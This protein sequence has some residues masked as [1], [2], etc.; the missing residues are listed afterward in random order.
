VKELSRRTAV[1]CV[2]L[3]T[4]QVAMLAVAADDVTVSTN[5]TVI[6][7][8]D[9]YPSPT[10]SGGTGGS[11]GSGGGGSGDSSGGGLTSPPVDAGGGEA[12]VDEGVSVRETGSSEASFA[13]NLLKNADLLD[14]DLTCLACEG[15][16]VVGNVLRIA[17]V[18]RN[19]G[20]ADMNATLVGNVF[21]NGA[22]FGV[23]G[24]ETQTVRGR[25][26]ENLSMNLTLREPGDYLV[27]AHV[28]YGGKMTGVSEMSFSVTDGDT[29]PFFF[30]FV[31]AVLLVA[32]YAAV[33]WRR[34][35]S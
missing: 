21:R 24:G 26:E 6:T 10:G 7:S 23:I 12:E 11:S 33:R 13:T 18:F 20:S 14:G 27:R 8:T 3:C 2:V 29:L 15:E 35:D 9:V 5:V 30:P 28:V 32:V 22:F 1:L 4:L 19:A 34:R 17:G 25:T 16:A 31:G